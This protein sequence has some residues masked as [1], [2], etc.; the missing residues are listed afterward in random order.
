MSVSL[1]EVPGRN[2]GNSGTGEEE[3]GASRRA[4]IVW[5]VLLVAWVCFIWGHSM[6]PGTASTAESD[7][8]ASVLCS[9]LPVLGHI[10]SGTLTFVIRKTAHF[11]EYAVL[12]LLLGKVVDGRR[13][14]WWIS[15]AILIPA[16]DETIQ[17]FVPGRSGMVRDVVLDFVGACA[18]LAICVLLG[19]RKGARSAEGEVRS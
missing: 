7:N 10:D 6:V 14:A 17:L 13:M 8:V 1:P 5:L 18:G 19:R 9:A 2:G 11:L 3:P 4:D 15:F 16:T 12:G